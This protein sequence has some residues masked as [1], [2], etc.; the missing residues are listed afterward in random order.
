LK[1]H[2]IMTRG[3]E[4]ITADQTIEQAAVKMR[5]SGI[6]DMPVVVGGEAVGMLTDRDITLRIVAEGLDPQTTYVTDAMTDE[7]F[8]CKEN[9][10]IETAARLMGDR[11][12]R[13]LLVMTDGRKLSGIVSIGDLARSVDK[14]LVGEVL[15]KIS[16]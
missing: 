13:R 5:E 4:F 12:V 10:D 15:K 16:L 2:E 6:G 7:V 14:E 3:A 11:R 1:V 8:S 9:D